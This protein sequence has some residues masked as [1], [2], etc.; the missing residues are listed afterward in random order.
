MYAVTTL[1][2][3]N[4]GDNSVEPTLNVE[5]NEGS[6]RSLVPNATNSD[7]ACVATIVVVSA[8]SDVTVGY[9]C[10]IVSC[11]HGSPLGPKKI[12]VLYYLHNKSDNHFSLGS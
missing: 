11:S 9:V 7:S 8:A 12:I 5:R 2:C 10:E 4:G 1:A 3:A 6:A